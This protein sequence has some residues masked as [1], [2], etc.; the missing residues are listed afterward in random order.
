V[1]VP[2]PS[3]APYVYWSATPPNRLPVDP[4]TGGLAAG[5]GWWTPGGG[6][7]PGPPPSGVALLAPGDSIS[8]RLAADP[9]TPIPVT[10]AH[11]RFACTAGGPV[12]LELY[13]VAPGDVLTKLATAFFPD[14]TSRASIDLDVTSAI[15][16][17]AVNIVCPAV[18]T[19]PAT[20]T[21]ET[22]HASYTD[23]LGADASVSTGLAEAPAVSGFAFGDP[24]LVQG[25]YDPGPVPPTASEQTFG[26]M[27][28]SDLPALYRDADEALADPL[29]LYRYLQGAGVGAD[30]LNATA[31]AV[32]NGALTTLTACPDE[33]LPWLAV[34]LGAV[35]G[36]TV[37]DT[38]AAIAARENGAAEGSAQAM[39]QYM[40]HYLTGTQT[41][42]VVPSG[43]GVAW[44]L[45]VRMISAE[46]TAAGGPDVIVAQL[47]AA[48]KVPAGWTVNPVL[49]NPLWSAHD[50]AYPLWSS[51]DGQT[52]AQHESV[53]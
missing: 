5:V 32:Y 7:T 24:V 35:P 48:G 44:T 9:Q 16:G 14:G 21:D 25:S 28:W 11:Y 46:T 36:N 26:A 12:V 34:V 52:W 10:P 42:H 38:R 43:T 37:N 8:S 1:L 27:V 51:W 6:S 13:G 4:I 23:L 40:A 33:W 31:T 53:T 29:Q 41:V 20:E 45:D 39:E 15:P 3:Y 22:S 19:D 50:A 17:L 18:F 2:S 49:I 47:T 30:D